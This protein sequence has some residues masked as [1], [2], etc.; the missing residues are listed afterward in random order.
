VYASQQPDLFLRAFTS[1]WP[2]LLDL[3]HAD[4]GI[5][6]LSLIRRQDAWRGHQG[7]ASG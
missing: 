2:M 1:V 4:R 7:T 5:F 6:Q 3:F